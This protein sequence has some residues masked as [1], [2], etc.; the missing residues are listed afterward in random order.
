MDVVIDT[1]SGAISLVSFNSCETALNGFRRA[2]MPYV[3]LYG[4][5]G[6]SYMATDS[7]SGGIALDA[8]PA[9]P[10]A[11]GAPQQQ[12]G[13]AAAGQ[14]ESAAGQGTRQTPGHS[15]TNTHE[16]GVDEP[17]IVKTDGRR[18][19]SIA[20]GRLKVVDVASRKVTGTLDVP[21]VYVSNMLISGDRALLVTNQS[22]AIVYD[23]PMP[24]GRGKPMPGMPLGMGSKLLLV[25]LVGTPRILGSL[26]VDGGYVDARQIGSVARVVVRSQPKLKFAY[27]DGTRTPASLLSENREIVS[28][29]PIDDWLPRYQ[30]EREGAKSEGRLVDCNRISHPAYYTGTGMLTVLTLD[31]TR[32]LGTGDPVSVAADGDT[33]Y[34]SGSSL[35]IA[36]DHQSRMVPMT[37]DRTTT[38]GIPRLPDRTQIH[39]F[40]IAGSGP[41]KYAGS[42]EVEGTLLNQF[43][44]S[45]HNGHLRVATTVGQPGGPNAPQQSHSMV[46]VLARGPNSLTEVG[47]VDGLGKG[48]RIY[49][50]RFFGPVG[51]VVT[52]RQVDPLY[53][54]DLSQPAKP[55]VVGELKITGYSAYLHPVGEGKILGVGQEA[56]DQGR[57][58]GSQVS[59]FD[60]ANPAAPN[61]LAQYQIEGGSSEVEYDA[62][63]F[64]Y[65]PE[66]NLVVVP[67]MDTKIARSLNG[68]YQQANYALVLRIDQGRLTEAGRI[69]HTN[70]MIRRSLVI[71]DELWTLSDAGL[72]VSGLDGLGQRAWI[73]LR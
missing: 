13:K 68:D 46:T 47:R 69:S 65:W 52:F 71:G 62:H 20:D 39:R 35:Y 45:E 38:P 56:T 8:V 51:Y 50:V 26:A 3:G 12:S 53:T 40:D 32:D 19:V 44:L 10:M 7:R 54:L 73:A 63:A 64:L 18:L 1:P 6:P 16:A 11:A 70:G 14:S 59:L 25:D 37:F 36:D 4:F 24:P 28:S 57:R 41:P 29:A 27:P 55:R 58:L 21:D 33:V 17:D 72:M 61:R 67:V 66:R 48:E 60:V 30:L 43:S 22:N 49:A 5:S 34:G 23:M 31:L 15:T 2:A 42:G 9:A